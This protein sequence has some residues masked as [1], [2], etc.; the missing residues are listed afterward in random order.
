MD[1]TLLLTIE[2][3]AQAGNDLL[4]LPP[5]SADKYSLG[6]VDKVNIVTP[7]NLVIEKA[8]E[9]A[10]PFDADSH[11]YILLIP[12]TQKDEIPIGSQ[13]WIKKS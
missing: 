11:V 1:E 8:A 3:V 2:S 10:I 5:L 7:N 13:V 6:A 9:F 12:N 4:I